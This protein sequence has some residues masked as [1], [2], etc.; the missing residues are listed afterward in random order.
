MKDSPRAAAD[1]A[2]PSSRS[3]CNTCQR[4]NPGSTCLTSSALASSCSRRSLRVKRP[5]AITLLQDA[6]GRRPQG[7]VQRLQQVLFLSRSAEIDEHLLFLLEARDGRV[8]SEALFKHDILEVVRCKLSDAATWAKPS[9]RSATK[10]PVRCQ[11]P[12]Q[13][14]GVLSNAPRGSSPRGTQ[15]ERRASTSPPETT[16][17]RHVVWLPLCQGQ[18]TKSSPRGAQRSTC[19]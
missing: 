16:T 12:C 14:S 18:P 9:S 10:E 6:S 3:T 8:R 2:R 15:V 7:E 17:R 1:S 19:T 5:A 11:V 4:Q 13:L